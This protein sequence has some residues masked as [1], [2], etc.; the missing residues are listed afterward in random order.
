[1]TRKEALVKRASLM[2]DADFR[3]KVANGDSVANEQLA[4]IARAIVGEPD[5]WTRAPVAGGFVRTAE[6]GIRL[7]ENA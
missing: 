1:M 5:N 7:D 3:A 2:N 6:G 4:Q